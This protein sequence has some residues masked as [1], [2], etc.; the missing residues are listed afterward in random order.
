MAISVRLNTQD[1]Q[2]FKSYAKT[3]NMTLS[4]LFRN[5]VFEKIEG[6]YD[7]AVYR[8]SLEEYNKNPVI[9]SHAEVCRLLGI[10]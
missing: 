8:E 6:E 10:E 2:L 1:E 7:L 3:N 5:A 9:Y 4:E